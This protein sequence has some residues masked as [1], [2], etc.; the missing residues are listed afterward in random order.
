MTVSHPAWIL[1]ADGPEHVRLPIPATDYLSEREAV[2]IGV[3]TGELTEL[4]IAYATGKREALY[5]SPLDGLP[6]AD[7]LAA[8]NARGY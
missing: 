6:I 1:T 5:G 4:R 2:V 3:G 7:H 8:K